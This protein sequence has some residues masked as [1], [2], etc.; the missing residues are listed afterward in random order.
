MRCRISHQH[1]HRFPHHLLGTSHGNGLLEGHSTP[2]TSGMF[3][4]LCGVVVW[5]GVVWCGVVWCGVVGCALTHNFSPNQNECT[6]E[7]GEKEMGELIDR[8]QMVAERRN[9]YDL[10]VVICMALLLAVVVVAFVYATLLSILICIRS[11][12][13]PAEQL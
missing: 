11:Q 2:S 4:L 3:L 6:D 9:L 12:E 1:L 5:C 8:T 13:L 7:W 10:F